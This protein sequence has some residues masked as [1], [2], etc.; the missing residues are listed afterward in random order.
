MDRLQ[1]EE[2]EEKRVHEAI[3]IYNHERLHMSIDWNTPQD[4][5]QY[6]KN[7]GPKDLALL[8]PPRGGLLRWPQDETSELFP[9]PDLR[10]QRQP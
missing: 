6:V 5:H 10:L 8:M 2:N 1:N 7:P 3:Y 9:L 4:I